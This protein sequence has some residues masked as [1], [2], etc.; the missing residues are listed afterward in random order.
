MCATWG[1]SL[2][3]KEQLDKDSK[4]KLQ[5]EKGKTNKME[6]EAPKWDWNEC[7][8]PQNPQNAIGQMNTCRNEGAKG[9]VGRA[10]KT[11]GVEVMQDQPVRQSRRLSLE[12]AK[13]SSRE[14]AKISGGDE[15]DEMQREQE[16]ERRASAKIIS[17]LLGKRMLVDVPDMDGATP[18][19]KA[20]EKKNLPAARCLLNAKCSAN[21]ADYCGLTP[22]HYICDDSPESVHLALL[23]LE[24]KAS[25]DHQDN[26]GNTP[27]NWATFRCLPSIVS[28]LLGHGADVERKNKWGSR[29]IHYAIYQGHK[30]PHH[31]QV[32]GLIL[33]R[34][35]LEPA[36]HRGVLPTDNMTYSQCQGGIRVRAM[37]QGQSRLPSNL[38]RHFLK[39]V[40]CCS[41][42]FSQSCSR[43]QRH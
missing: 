10:E 36:N 34:T 43:T 24:H 27:L 30:S 33:P 32:L 41:P 12:A 9:P 39:H 18:L 3:S 25:P 31:I 13:S 11:G 37:L 15:L 19:H 38:C 26:D 21:V 23:L 16:Q 5:E 22:L 14:A 35:K 2:E 4:G 8:I 28:V 42:Q 17:Y 7:P 40:F 1:A 20:V 29:A 6:D